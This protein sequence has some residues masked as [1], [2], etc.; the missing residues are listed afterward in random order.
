LDRLRNSDHNTIVWKLICDVSIDES[1]KQI[2][3][4]REANY[5]RM[6]TWFEN[7]DWKKKFEDLDSNGKWQKFCAT[8]ESAVQNF[9]PLGN[10]NSRNIQNG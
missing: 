4:F 10:A 8:I 7:V 2:R 3:L 9:V 6:K 1:K 5:D